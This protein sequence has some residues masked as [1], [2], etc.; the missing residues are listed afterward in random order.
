VTT[1]GPQFL[2]YSPLKLGIRKEGLC[3]MKGDILGNINFTTLRVITFVPL[4]VG[5]ITNEETFDGVRILITPIKTMNMDKSRTTKD[6]TL[7]TSQ[8]R[9]RRIEC[10]HK[11]NIINTL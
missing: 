8:K 10:G 11:L 1:Q 6:T 2:E 9:N 7:K 3:F 4:F 5:G